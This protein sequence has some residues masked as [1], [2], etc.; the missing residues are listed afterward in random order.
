MA[1]IVFIIFV[2]FPCFLK[3]F[4]LW[5]VSWSLFLRTATVRTK[6]ISRIFLFEC[7][8]NFL[9]VFGV[10]MANCNKAFMSISKKK[11]VGGA[12]WIIMNFEGVIIAH[13]RRAF[14]FI[15]SLKEAGMLNELF[16]RRTI[17]SKTR[18]Y[19]LMNHKFLVM[20]LNKNY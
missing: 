17:S 18:I 3:S 6:H 4:F 5:R 13:S 10:W 8:K 19:V 12:S 1:L 9:S 11:C 14:S 2:H 7:I 20:K 15:N 16:L